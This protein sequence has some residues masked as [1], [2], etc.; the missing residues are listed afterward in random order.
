MIKTKPATTE[1]VPAPAVDI[2]SSLSGKVKMLSAVL[3]FPN[4]SGQVQR[5]PCL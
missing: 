3:S 5:R 4:W 1:A 2:A